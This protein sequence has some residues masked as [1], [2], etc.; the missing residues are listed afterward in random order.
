[1]PRWRYVAVYRGT[2]DAENE[3]DARLLALDATA[4][5]YP[6]NFDVEL[7]DPTATSE[8]ESNDARV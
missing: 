6:H 7:A 3:R 8:S 1:M 2:V 4:E 5:T